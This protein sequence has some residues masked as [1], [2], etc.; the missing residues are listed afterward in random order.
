MDRPGLILVFNGSFNFIIIV[1]TT[2]VPFLTWLIIIGY[3]FTA[4]FLPKRLRWTEH[5]VY[6]YVNYFHPIIMIIVFS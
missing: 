1:C 3:L 4:P 6:W 5:V 2:L